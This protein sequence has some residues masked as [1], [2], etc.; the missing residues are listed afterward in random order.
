MHLS[1]LRKGAHPSKR[2]QSLH[3]KC[4]E[5]DLKFTILATLDRGVS[6]AEMYALEQKYM[7][8]IEPSLNNSPT[9]GSIKGMKR[10]AD[11]IERMRQ[12]ALKRDNSNRKSVKLAPR[13]S[14]TKPWS[15]ERRARWD[16]KPDHSR[17]PETCARIGDA[18]RGK[19]RTP[20]QV[21]RFRQAALRT[22]ELRRQA[23]AC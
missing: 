6:K 1:D 4:G 18:L 7:D 21:E 16:A 22:H 9:A 3:D 17:S 20:E 5:D 12:S 8:E 19:K 14:P 10:S 23:A 11:T 15:D 2:L 13:T